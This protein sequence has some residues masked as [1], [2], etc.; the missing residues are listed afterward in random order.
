[1]RPAANLNSLKSRAL[2][3]PRAALALLGVAVLI[4]HVVVLGW[5]P[6]GATDGKTLDEKELRLVTR[7]VPAA[8]P[9]PR[10]ASPKARP[11]APRARVAP[12]ADP[13]DAPAAASDL[14]AGNR[15]VAT[16]DDTP[17][18]DSAADTPPPI[19]EPPPPAPPEAAPQPPPVGLPAS[20][21]L[22]YDMTGESKGLTY[23]AGA[24]L[25]WQQ[26]GSRYQ[27]RMEVSAFLIGSRVQTSEGRIGPAGLEPERFADKARKA[28]L[29]THFDRDAQRIV[30]S[31]NMP[32]VPLPPGTQDR[33]GVFLQIASQLAGD[34][35]RYPPG[36]AI[37]I[38]TA[39]TRD[40]GDWVFEVG[41]TE[42]LQLAI[43]PQATVKLER[44]P[45][46]PYDTRVEVWFAPGLA[47]L[48]V[49]MRIT[50]QSGDFIDQTL[51]SAERP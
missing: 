32:E 31:S 40:L 19:A 39:G 37:A 21:R 48:P 49:R 22:K 5:V 36:T 11:A 14:D 30:F 47:Y 1:M 15:P 4:G 17:P 7:V 34:P 44:T 9:P 26:D 10:P 46:K 16:A 23:H 2:R 27:A 13:S 42:T 43:G 12:A 41:N 51:T 29:A 3:V 6:L 24:E 25:L 38:P 18:Q 50:Q 33:L 20:V 35:Q 45:R 28:E 8:A